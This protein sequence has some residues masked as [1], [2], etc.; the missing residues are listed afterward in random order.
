M[1]QRNHDKLHFFWI[2]M[3]NV[4]VMGLECVNL[5]KN[6]KNKKNMKSLE[7]FWNAQNLNDDHE[8]FRLRHEIRIHWKVVDIRNY[9]RQIWLTF[10]PLRFVDLGVIGSVL[11][12]LGSTGDFD[13]FCWCE[14][15]GRM[16]AEPAGSFKNDY[17]SLNLVFTRSRFDNRQGLHSTFSF[18]RLK[19]QPGLAGA[20][21]IRLFSRIH[22]SRLWMTT[23]L[24]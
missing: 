5:V 16:L 17:W 8:N 9:S 15:W 7:V 19:I 6:L 13:L 3:E 24:F 22:L 11:T 1:E 21:L 20:I 2:K 10:F 18:S 12:S 14:E 23:L 4:N